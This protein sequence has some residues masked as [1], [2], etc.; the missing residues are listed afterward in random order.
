MGA[1]HGSTRCARCGH[2][3]TYPSVLADSGSVP[4][5]TAIVGI[6]IE[7]KQTVQK[8]DCGLVG[9]LQDGGGQLVVVVVSCWDITDRSAVRPAAPANKRYP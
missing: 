6:D 5:P 8:A 9:R 1:T 3:T 4:W 7:K 2:G